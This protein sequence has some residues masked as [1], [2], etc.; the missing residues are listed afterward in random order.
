MFNVKEIIKR[1]QMIVSL[2]IM[3]I[4]ESLFCFQLKKE[5]LT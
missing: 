1:E 2:F 5:F 3:L 4:V